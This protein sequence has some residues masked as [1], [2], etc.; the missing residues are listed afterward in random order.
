[1]SLCCMP[2][3]PQGR[4][5]LETVS[6][7]EVG[8]TDMP[9]VSLDGGIF[10]MGSDSPESFV[11]DGEGPVRPV[12]V[13]PFMID[14][15]ATRVSDFAAFVVATGYVTDAERLGSSFVFQG[16]FDA[17]SAD[18]HPSVAAAPWWGEVP[19]VDWRR[20]AGDHRKARPDHPV[21]HVSWNDAMAFASWA[22]KRLPTEA[23]W[24]YAARGGLASK[25]YPWGDELRP[26]GLVMCNIWEGPFP[27]R[28]ETDGHHGTCNVDA[29][30][31][32]GFGLFNT[33]GNTWEWCADWFDAHHH[34]LASRDNPPGPVSG[35][36]KLLKGGSN[37][38][39]PSYCNRYRIAA[40]TGNSPQ[41]SAGNVGFRC[42]VDCSG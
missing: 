42:V 26:S 6:G 35:E 34:Q 7:S 5:R 11:S 32:N 4:A 36:F 14:T 13:R 18:H 29:Y 20:P 12:R 39:H 9:V 3:S 21:V 19:G 28:G 30:A 27:K 10:L 23:E 17:V 31:P 22:G 41:S 25:T 15:M 1:M 24:E 37:L 16:E 2:K 33:V 8:S 38:C 40:R